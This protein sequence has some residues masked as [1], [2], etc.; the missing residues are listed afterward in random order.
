MN[1]STTCWRLLPTVI[2]SAALM[3]CGGDGGNYSVANPGTSPP[4][5]GT[6]TSPGDTTP[7]R[8]KAFRAAG[9]VTAAPTVQTNAS[10]GQTVSVAVLAQDGVRTLTTAAVA[11]AQAAAIQASLVP[12][13]LVD[14][15]PSATDPNVVQV[16]GDAT[17]TFNV[18]LAKGTSTAAQFNLQKYGAAVTR[19]AG[20][21]GPM[22]AAGWVYGKTG[23]TVTVGDG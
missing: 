4:T 21:P 15:L 23:S 6:G 10:G 12:G 17:G 20:A 5:A 14:W 13:N 9:L 8:T 18:I 3:A 11:P 2:A 1:L 16:A 19:N 7:V 22:V